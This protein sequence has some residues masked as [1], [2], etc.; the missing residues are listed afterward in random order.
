MRAYQSYLA[1]ALF[2]ICRNSADHPGG[3]HLASR[4]EELLTQKTDERTGEEIAADI[5]SRAG[6]RMVKNGRI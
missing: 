5:I 2:Y 3:T 4:W 1:D 6:L